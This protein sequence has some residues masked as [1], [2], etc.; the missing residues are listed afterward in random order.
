MSNCSCKRIICPDGVW[1]KDDLIGAH[2]KVASMPGSNFF[3]IQDADKICTIKEIYF[4]VSLDGKTIT[5]IELNEYPGV[6]FTWKDLLIEGLIY[7]ESSEN[8]PD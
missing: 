8:K 2:V 7:E 4:R 1:D 5:V 6:I 3:Q